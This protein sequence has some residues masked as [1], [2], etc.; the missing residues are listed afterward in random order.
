M[1]PSTSAAVPT[2]PDRLPSPVRTGRPLTTPAAPAGVRAGTGTGRRVLA[3]VL[4]VLGLAAVF[5]VAR[6]DPAAAQQA[7]APIEA[8]AVPDPAM[9]VPAPVTVDAEQPGDST[10]DIN[11]NT[12]EKPSKSITIILVLTVLSI[13]P[14]LLVMLTPFTRIVIV[15]TLARNALGIPSVPP[16]QVIVGLAL[17]LSVFTMA[18]TL[19]AM[20]EVAFQ[21][22][23]NDKIT[24][25]QAWEAGQ[26]PLKQYLLDNT[27]TEELGLFIDQ[28][29]ENGEARPERPEDVSMTTL[30]PAYILSELQTAFII[31]FVIF[32]PFLVIDLVVSAVLMSLGMMML[33]PVVV[34]LPFKILLFVMVGGW[35]L[36]VET[37]IRSFH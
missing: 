24:E 15:L 17:F 30:V 37:L 23:M 28:A 7:P 25:Q 32:I 26:V 12:G 5:A 3:L 4:L 16:N 27:R 10:L 35:T 14:S 34:S 2:P 20:N 29:A 18:P 19:K 21:P 33:P 6:P 22:L 1:N 11:L 13:A 31:G 36:V 9:P 8:P